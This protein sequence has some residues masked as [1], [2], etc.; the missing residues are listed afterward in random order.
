MS[1]I[2]ISVSQN[3]ATDWLLDGFNGIALASD[4]IETYVIISLFTDLGTNPGDSYSQ[5]TLGSKLYTLFNTAVSN[6]AQLL[7][8][9]QDFC[10]QALQWMLTLS[11]VQSIT[12][13]PSLLTSSVLQ[14]QVSVVENNNPTPQTFTFP[15]S[16]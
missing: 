9:A 8:Q 13:T 4:E 15:V 10:N 5:F 14:L 16:L 6:Q 11:L 1:D 12:V 2:G 7:K 3:L